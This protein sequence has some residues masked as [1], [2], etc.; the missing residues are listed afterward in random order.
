VPARRKFLR[1]PS[2]EA[3]YIGRLVGAY[4]CHRSDIQWSLT[5]DGRRAIRTGGDGDDV[6]AALGVFGTELANEVLLLT[7][8]DAD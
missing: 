7:E 3:S 1:Q 6:A 4:A 5:I 2:T 8:L